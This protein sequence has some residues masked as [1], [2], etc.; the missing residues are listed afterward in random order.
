MN[1]IKID[2]DNVFYFHKV[3]KSLLGNTILNNKKPAIEAGFFDEDLSINYFNT[4]NSG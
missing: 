3:Y 1:L 4:E 2:N